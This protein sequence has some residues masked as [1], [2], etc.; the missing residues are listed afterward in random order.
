MLAGKIEC[1]PAR[2]QAS[3]IARIAA[4]NGFKK[5]FRRAPSPAPRPADLSRLDCLPS[6][7]PACIPSCFLACMTSSQLSC[8]VECMCSCIH[9]CMNTGQPSAI[10]SRGEVDGGTGGTCTSGSSASFE[11]LTIAATIGLPP[12]PD[13]PSP[14]RTCPTY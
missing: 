7:I 10:R 1:I 11:S 14:T 2:K 8:W 13:G 4:G 9:A 3:V 5:S 6:C 12:G